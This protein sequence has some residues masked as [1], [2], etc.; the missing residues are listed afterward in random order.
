MSV[1]DRLPLPARMPIEVWIVGII[2]FFSTIGYGILG[3]AL[4]P[5]A[6]EFSVGVTAMSMAVS[7]FAAVRLVTNIA[8]ARVLKS[9][10]LWAI[11]WG[12]LLWQGVFT[13]G[14]AVAGDFTVFLVM[15]SVSGLGSAAYTISA[16]ALVLVVAPAAVRGRA[17]GVYAAGMS[18]GMVTGPVI[19]GALTALGTRIP[20]YGYGL[21][22]ILSAAVAFFTLRRARHARTAEEPPPAQG[23]P[24]GGTGGSLRALFTDPLIVAA[25]M[26]QVINGW[27]FYGMRTTSMPLEMAALGHTTAVIGLLLALASLTQIFG[28]AAAGPMSDR[29]GRRP[30]SFVALGIAVV[31]VG[32][33]LFSAQPAVAF[34]T[35]A[36]VGLAGGMISS[37]A[38]AILGDSPRGTGSVSLSAYWVASDLAAVV[39][40]LAS[41]LL[42]ESLGFPA[43]VA[44]AGVLI[45]LTA[46]SAARIGPAGRGAGSRAQD[47]DAA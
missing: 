36:L 12:G 9:F 22:L 41:G 24:G 2:G 7:G 21:A 43:A 1:H 45:A 37:L 14:S 28:S 35:F 39:G 29:I 33:L 5:L 13:L 10:R 25:L 15:R 42:T 40:P 30:P 6:A 26:F 3:P 38:P 44:L 16:T 8:F 34:T 31:A 23:R 19:G 20:L 18:M 47:P 27:I 4:P 46:L 17:M 32:G 11:L